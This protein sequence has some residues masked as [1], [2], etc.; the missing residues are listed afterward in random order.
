[1]TWYKF[2]HRH[3]KG[4]LCFTWGKIVA[5]NFSQLARQKPRVFFMK[6]TNDN[7]N[8]N[9]TKQLNRQVDFIYWLKILLFPS[10]TDA[11]PHPTIYKYPPEI[12]QNPCS[13]PPTYKEA[14]ASSS[15]RLLCLLALFFGHGFVEIEAS[16]ANQPYRTAFHFQPPKNWMN[17][18]LFFTNHFSFR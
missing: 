14:M 16:P 6:K 7:N 2:F 15:V 5:Q 10:P 4:N 8:N 13:F 11:A 3:W 18:T 9:T 17:G 1:M 12:T